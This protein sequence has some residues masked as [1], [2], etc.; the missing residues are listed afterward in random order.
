M[1]DLIT[2]VDSLETG[3]PFAAVLH[4]A[5]DMRE[6]ALRDA[7]AAAAGPGTR[8]IRVG[9]S[10]SSPLT[11]ERLVFQLSGAR[12]DGLSVTNST[13][14]Q[15]CAPR[16]GERRVVLVIE[17]AET[18]D[19]AALRA[20][21]AAGLEARNFEHPL[22]VLF[23]GKPA[24]LSLLRDPDLALIR[25][26][27]MPDATELDELPAGPASV[28]NDLPAGW[29]T[30]GP[31]PKREGLARLL[32]SAEPPPPE[33][34]GNAMQAALV[35][36]MA[37]LSTVISWRDPPPEDLAPPA[38]AVSSTE[39]PGSGP[40]VPER[41]FVVGA[42]GVEAVGVEPGTATAAIVNAPATEA[43]VVEAGAPATPLQGMPASP[44]EDESSRLRREFDV[45]VR[46]SGQAASRLSLAQRQALF[47]EFLRWRSRGAP[48]TAAA[49]TASTQPPTRRD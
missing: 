37:M 49:V 5:D 39:A 13:I 36:T 29:L 25:Y 9:N 41:D 14:G 30:P 11:I 26:T 16:A 1:L 18:L 44:S 28:P 8:T 20:L 34:N 3:H 38:Y 12:E 7:V 46:N 48:R 23:A 4:E 43:P 22:Q 32:T 21:Q 15:L 47:D 6:G 2:A 10:L 42:A 35:L 17:Q 31:M 40:G 27:V 33:R 24:F 19:G 45:F